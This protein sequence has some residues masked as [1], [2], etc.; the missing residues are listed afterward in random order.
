[1]TEHS[2]RIVSGSVFSLAEVISIDILLGPHRSL[3]LTYS[4]IKKALALAGNAA[5]AR[6]SKTE[7]KGLE[8]EGLE[9]E[10]EAHG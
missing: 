3:L 9:G 5:A 2:L 8:G 1:M 4:I 10:G 7:G 6:E